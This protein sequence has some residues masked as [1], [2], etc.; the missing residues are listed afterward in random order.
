MF[1]SGEPVSMFLL[2]CITSSV[3]LILAESEVGPSNS[4]SSY[5]TES[6]ECLQ[7]ELVCQTEEY[8]VRHYSPT[9]W[10]S[11]DAEAYLMGV[12]AAMAFRRLY[13]Y[14]TG[15][16]EAGIQMEATAPV[17]V[18]VP[19]ETHT[20]EP[21][22]YTLSFLLPSVFQQ[23]RPPAPTNDK[24]Y[25]TEMPEMD[26]YVRS[27]GGWM[28]S[29]SSR[30]HTHLLT[31]E[32]QRVNATYNHTHHYAVGYD[33]PLKLLHRHNEVWYVVNGEPVCNATTY[34]PTQSTNTNTPTASTANPPAIS[35]PP[36]TE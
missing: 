35:D 8:E 34:K 2:R 27:Y 25:F 20:W 16:N 9:R 24:L 21:A 22:I 29:V 12:G 32:L 31:K 7:F 17:L 5:C 14:I 10:V 3:L 33:S 18:E 23:D 6:K 1:L 13:Q 15:T 30:L 19:E 36:A 26:V 11:T 4:P 28:L